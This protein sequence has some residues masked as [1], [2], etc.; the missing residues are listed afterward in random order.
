M[1]AISKLSLRNLGR[2]QIFGNGLFQQPS[3]LF[4]FLVS[5]ILFLLLGPFSAPI[6]LMFVLKEGRNEGFELE[7]EPAKLG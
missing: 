4:W 3:D 6:A 5:F 1:A 2:M 7:P